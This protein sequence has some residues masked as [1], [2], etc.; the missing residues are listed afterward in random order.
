MHEASLSLQINQPRSRSSLCITRRMAMEKNKSFDGKPSNHKVKLL[1]RFGGKIQTRSQDHQLTYIGGDTKI[2]TVDRR[3]KFCDIFT[4]IFTLCNLSSEFC[5]K[6]QLPGED[7]D[8]LVSVIDDDDLEHMMVEYDRLLGIPTD[9]PA[10]LRLFLF[11]TNPPVK[12]GSDT[13]FNPDFL[14][15]F[16]KELQVNY[17]P[18]YEIPQIPGVSMPEISGSDPHEGALV[19]TGIPGQ[20]S[21]ESHVIYGEFAAQFGFHKGSQVYTTA[22]TCE[23]PQIQGMGIPDVYGSNPRGS[24]VTCEGLA[25]QLVYPLALTTTGFGN[26]GGMATVVIFVVKGVVGWR[27]QQRWW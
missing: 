1:C 3:I 9:K 8:A 26:D 13:P 16:D 12:A 20:G 27:R 25:G 15:G 22:T 24:Q 23:S 18:T 6:Y 19:K 2:L 17:T 5:L 10:R 7:L 4:K 14:F 21:R 11:P